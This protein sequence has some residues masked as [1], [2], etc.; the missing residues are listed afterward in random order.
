MCIPALLW[1]AAAFGRCVYLKRHWTANDDRLYG[2]ALRK[3]LSMEAD[4]QLRVAPLWF[5][6]VSAITHVALSVVDMYQALRWPGNVT[7]VCPLKAAD[8]L[9][10]VR[11]NHIRLVG[12]ELFFYVS[13]ALGWELKGIGAVQQEDVELP[14]P[15]RAGSIELPRVVR[16]RI[17]WS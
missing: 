1:I 10:M 14:K 16:F 17:S 15:K 12:F 7:I 9:P 5:A 8:C 4:N 6:E 11:A 2:T 3:M 13:V